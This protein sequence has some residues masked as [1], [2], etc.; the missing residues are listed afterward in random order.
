MPRPPV[1]FPLLLL[2]LPPLAPG[3]GLRG[4]GGRRPQCGPCRPERC[5]APARCPAPR[6]AERDECGCCALCLGAEGA[7]CGGRAGARCGPG[8]VCAS[9]AAGAGPEGTGLCVCA[10][11]GAV[12]GSDGRSY[13]SVCALRLRAR[14]A[15]RAH[16]GHLHKARDGPC[17]FAPVV[18]LPPR[19][20]HNVT[21]AQVYLS[22]EVRAVP[23][24][25][26]TWRKVTQSP[27]G[28]QVL[29]DLPGDH[30]NI[31]VQVRG[32]PS[33]HEA[34]AWILINPLR[35]EDEGV[36]QCHSAN[37]VGEAQSHGTVMVTGLSKHQVLR[38]PA[39]GDCV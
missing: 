3:L 6:I 31:G 16:P 17:E 28:T 35:K 38:F 10:Q 11:R 26:I 4:A 30:V 20:V 18:V 37:V 27:E 19:S 14:H 39:L 24:P 15:P 21:G 34:T 22:C 1:L 9:R 8:L 29:E 2:L 13:P 12:C 7:S 36:Y 32:G 5:T 33:D 23:T 25:V